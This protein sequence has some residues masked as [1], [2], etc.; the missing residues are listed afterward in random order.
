MNDRRQVLTRAKLATGNA[1]Q[2]IKTID[3]EYKH[4]DVVLEGVVAYD[5]AAQGRRPGVLMV[6][7]WN[8]VS[9]FARKRAAMLAE[10]GYVGFVA[11]I[12]GKGIRPTAFQECQQEAGKY[13]KNITLFRGRVRAAFDALGGHSATDTKRIGAIGYC[14]GGTG[15]LELARDGADLAGVV[16]FHGGLGTPNPADANNIK[17][18]V[19]VLHGADDP[20][21]PPAEVAAF[22]KEMRDAKVDWEL[23]AYGGAVHSFTNWTIKDRPTANTAYNEKVDRRSWIAM[24]N[25]FEEVFHS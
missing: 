13:Y 19:L 16:S 7:E 14:F 11:D 3:I 8:G 6:P 12:Y 22:E 10:L 15:V 2:M 18:R 23:V 4:D 25:F 20:L 24:K 5:D 9:D 17:G 21:V 1:T